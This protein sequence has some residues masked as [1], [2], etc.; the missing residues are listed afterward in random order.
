MKKWYICLALCLVGLGFLAAIFFID[1][2]Q[3]KIM[4]VEDD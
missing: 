1:A 3:L 2:R 4:E